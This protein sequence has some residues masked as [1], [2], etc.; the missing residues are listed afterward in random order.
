[1]SLTDDLE[2]AL[3]ALVNR[4]NNDAGMTNDDAVIAAEAALE[5]LYKSRAA[6]PINP[7]PLMEFAQYIRRTGDTRLASM[8]IA[9]I[10]KATGEQQ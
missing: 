5:R 7:D 10:N 3:E 6:K 4:C 9:V 8:A 2:S 1:M